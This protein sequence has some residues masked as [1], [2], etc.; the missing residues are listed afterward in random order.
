ML[1]AVCIYWLSVDIRACSGLHMELL[2]ANVEFGRRTSTNR[3]KSIHGLGISLY[4]NANPR[5]CARILTACHRCNEDVKIRLMDSALRRLLDRLCREDEV[6]AERRMGGRTYQKPR[7][8]AKRF[9]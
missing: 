4:K 1:V 8:K 5:E 7:H 2:M 6:V 9:G 3:Y